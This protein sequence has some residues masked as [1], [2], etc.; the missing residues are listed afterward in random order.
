MCPKCKV[1]TDCKILGVDRFCCGRC[2]TRWLQRG[3]KPAAT[4]PQNKYPFG[5]FLARMWMVNP[6]LLCRKHLLG[7]HMDIHKLEQAI[8]AGVSIKEMLDEQAIQ[9]SARYKRHDELVLEMKSR[10]Y[11]HKS[12]L[13]KGNIRGDLHHDLVGRGGICFVDK[14]KSLR[15]LIIRCPECAMRIS[16]SQHK[17][18]NL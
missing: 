17:G 11:N 2:N 14:M 1:L 16:G 18:E 8:R 6:K 9:P 10:G 3:A 12:P 13:N 15:D 7:E 5:T 4:A